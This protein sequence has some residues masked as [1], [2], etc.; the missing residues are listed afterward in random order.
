MQ[1][2][3]LISVTLIKRDGASLTVHP[4]KEDVGLVLAFDSVNPSK[5]GVLQKLYRNNVCFFKHHII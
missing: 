1:S 5:R 4:K 2:V 3:T